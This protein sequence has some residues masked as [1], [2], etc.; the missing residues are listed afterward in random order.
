MNDNLHRD[1]IEATRLTRAGRLREATAVLQRALPGGT[2]PGTQ[3]RSRGDSADA[4]E[5][6][7]SLII[8]LIPE[9]IEVTAPQPSSRIA[10]PPGSGRHHEPTGTAEETAWHHVPEALRRFVEWVNR[11]GSAP[12]R[13][14]MAEPRSAHAPTIAPESGQFVA[15]SYSNEAGSLAYKLYIP[16][17]YRG[18]ALPLVVMLHGCTQSPDD[19]AVGT[20]MNALAEYTDR[21]M[22]IVLHTRR[23]L[24]ALRECGSEHDESQ[25]QACP[26]TDRSHLE[27]SPRLRRSV[28]WKRARTR[29]RDC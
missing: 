28:A 8:D 13:G 3:H 10:Q 1:M 12:G 4:P 27:H 5:G 26:S 11:T 18:Q 22:D 24:R 15:R 25:R 17:G 23:L 19:F 6:C 29:A 7:G 21:R 16:S 9:T 14:G 20:G 2:A